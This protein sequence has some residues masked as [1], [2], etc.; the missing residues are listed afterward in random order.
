MT[1]AE[2]ALVYQALREAASYTRVVPRKL[3][4]LE[5]AKKMRDEYV[6]GQ[7]RDRDDSHQCDGHT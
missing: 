7:R 1:I 6:D 4:Y 5:L 2:K 3:M